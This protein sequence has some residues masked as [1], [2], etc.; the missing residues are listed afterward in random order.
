MT[1]TRT[2]Y[3]PPSHSVRR[4]MVKI[5][6]TRLQRLCRRHCGQVVHHH[7]PA[8][9]SYT[10]LSMTLFAQ[11]TEKLNI[12]LIAADDVGYADLSCTGLADDV[13]TPNID[14]I[15]KKGVRF[16][17]AY[18]TAPVCQKDQSTDEVYSKTVSAGEKIAVPSHTGKDKSQYG[19]PHM[20]LMKQNE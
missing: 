18:V 20:V 11:N 15:A 14:R 1:A 6:S 9:I 19:I 12:I 10:S 7:Q 16:T 3:D 17:N 2:D 8:L 4:D 13:H 5:L